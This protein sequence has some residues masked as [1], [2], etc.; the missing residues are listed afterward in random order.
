MNFSEDLVTACVMT[1]PQLGTL[2][3]P[4]DSDG[5]RILF[6]DF[7]NCHEK[8]FLLFLGTVGKIEAETIRACQEQLRSKT[9][10]RIP[11]K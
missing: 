7:T 1:Y 9:K 6:L 4:E 10:Q 11:E 8:L 5:V 2:Q 3:I